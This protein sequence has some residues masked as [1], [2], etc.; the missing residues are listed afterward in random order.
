MIA[1]FMHSGII[2]SMKDTYD[3]ASVSSKKCFHIRLI[4]VSSWTPC[5]FGLDYVVMRTDGC[6]KAPVMLHSISFSRLTA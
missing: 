6:T 2:L 1:C 3:A 5:G 4:A